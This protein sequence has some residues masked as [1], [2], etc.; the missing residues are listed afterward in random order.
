MGEDITFCC[1]ANKAQGLNDN[2]NPCNIHVDYFLQPPIRK[3]KLDTSPLS[4][5]YI[6]LQNSN[7]IIYKYNVSDFD[8]FQ[9]TN[10]IGLI[11]GIK[12][13][14]LYNSNFK[15]PMN[16]KYAYVFEREN[17]K[18]LDKI[19]ELHV[20]S[21][22]PEYEEPEADIKWI[23][24]NND[25]VF[26]RI[27]ISKYHFE[28]QASLAHEMLNALNFEIKKLKCK[29]L[30]EGLRGDSVMK[31][32]VGLLVWDKINI[33]RKTIE[34]SCEEVEIL[35]EHNV[36]H[37]YSVE[38]LRKIYYQTANS[39]NKWIDYYGNMRGDTRKIVQ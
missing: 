10:L 6:H 28:S 15:R 39:I 32:M 9:Q 13:I 21:L 29:K 38:Y 5:M 8:F 4:L 14:E 1:L 17:V 22:F 36:I 24:S 37:E 35:L 12:H 30:L 34:S 11:Y 7:E 27:C 20:V 33:E 2:N 18:S 23:T 31:R 19:T 3:Q 16:S 25:F 26:R